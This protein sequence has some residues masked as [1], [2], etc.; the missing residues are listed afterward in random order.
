M[1]VEDRTQ[2]EMLQRQCRDR[3]DGYTCRIL[4]CA[5][6]GCVATG[7]LDVYSQ[8]RELCKEDEGIR[9]ELEK[10]VPH[11][12]IVKSGCQGFCELGPLVRIEPQHCQYV[13]VQP[14]DC[15]E[16]VEKTVKQGIPVE[17]L[18]YKKEG[19]S[20]GA[21]DEIPYFARQ[22]RIVLEQC[23][24][25]DAESVEEYMAAG[26]FSALKKALFAM[27][28]EAVIA[29]VE[30]SGLRGRG[31]GG[32]PAGRKWRQV[33]AHKEEPLKYIVCNGD[34]G[35]PGA[36]MDGSVMEGDPCRLIEGMMLAG[37]AV[38]A[39]EG[40]IYVRAEYPLSVARLRQAIGQMEERGLLGDSILGTG[41]SFH[42]H[43][44]RGAGAFVCGEG[45]ALTA[46]IEG[47]R[48]MPRVKPPR[49]VDQG[50]WGKPTV[51][52]NVET[53][54]NLPGII[55]NGGK[56]F[57]TIG[58]ENSTGTK[59]FSVTGCIENTGLVEVPMGTTLRTI[60]YDICGGLK[61][62][63]EFKAVQIGGPSGGCLTEEHLD[64]PLD[65]DSVQKFNVIIGS[66]GLV[67]MDKHTCMVEVARFFM[68]FTQ[69]ESCGKCV[70]C[71][72]GTKRM[73]EI[74]ER[75]VEGKGEPDDIERLEQLADMISN[76][77][78]CGLG[79]SAPLP[80]ISTI[81][82]F[83]KEYLEHINEK[84]CRAG[85]CQ[86]MKTYIIDE[87]T[88]R[89]CSKCAKG[90]PA[91]AI[92]GELKHVFTIRQQQCIKCGACAEACPFGAV[93]IQS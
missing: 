72:E 19:I 43:I 3:K 87:E 4:V 61:E 8:L 37:Y 63:S 20:Y 78:L 40:F 62:G 13:K 28:P 60:I 39:S 68:N 5:G 12:G 44:N 65:F 75:I 7:S 67:V 11:I 26:G 56:W 52:N 79:K 64:E 93:H 18:F 74:L 80:V 41:F 32:F 86:S 51:L 88:C 48:G 90:C 50:L 17:R 69:R 9:V 77:A 55:V 71:R 23:G 33:A 31:G 21:V 25:I 36:F 58:T 1:R 84:K 82:A 76:T 6:T 2:L 57:R 34:E 92:A 10:D 42:L 22:T 14:E 24:N 49:T 91:G 45:S 38:G 16:I 73:L 54:A 46:S 70:P 47:H 59:T 29:E 15:E 35:D 27:T 89:G 83:R 85:V 81:K 66:G 30:F 53:Y